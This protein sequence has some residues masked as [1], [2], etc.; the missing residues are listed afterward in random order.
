MEMV[1][2]K[3]FMYQTLYVSNFICIKPNC[4]KILTSGSSELRA[5]TELI[6]PY[7]MRYL[8]ESLMWHIASQV[9]ELKKLVIL[10]K[11][12]LV[13]LRSNYDKPDAMKELFRRLQSKYFIYMAPD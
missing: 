12:T 10:N 13:A 4:S 7:G 5:L 2:I 8:S 6:G 9:T 11:D 3:L 1:C